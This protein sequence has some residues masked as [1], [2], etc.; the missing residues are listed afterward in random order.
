MSFKQP[1]DTKITG[2][3]FWDRKLG[4]AQPL[5]VFSK[6][7]RAN[8]KALVSNHFRHNAFRPKGLL[9][10]ALLYGGFGFTVGVFYKNRF[11]YQYE[12]H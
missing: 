5:S 1:Y 8:T 12:Y 10:F 7:A 3:A 11:H 9:S 6:Q 4:D 2:T